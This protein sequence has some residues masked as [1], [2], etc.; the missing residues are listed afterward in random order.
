MLALV[1][2]SAI[3]LRWLPHH[4]PPILILFAVASAAA[5]TI[6]LTQRR[7][8]RTSVSGI[9]GGKV[10]ADVNAVLWTALTIVALDALGIMVITAG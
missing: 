4:G 6:Y 7:R 9:S 5:A 10:N 8:Y 3:F 2:A 1:T